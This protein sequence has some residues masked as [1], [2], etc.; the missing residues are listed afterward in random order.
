MTIPIVYLLHRRQQL[1]QKHHMNQIWLWSTMDNLDERPHQPMI[2]RFIRSGSECRINEISVWE[3]WI[4]FSSFSWITI[5]QISS[6]VYVW[7]IDSISSISFFE[8]DWCLTMELISLLVDVRL[9][10]FDLNLVW[11]WIDQDKWFLCFSLSFDIAWFSRSRS[12][13]LPMNI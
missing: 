4:T 10:L 8:F 2:Y 3:T 1:W 6:V 11:K 5:Y 9:F 12:Q 13:I 7:G